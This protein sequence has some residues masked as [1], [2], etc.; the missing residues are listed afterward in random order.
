MIAEF[1]LFLEAFLKERNLELVDII[2]RYEGSDLVLRI[3]ADR[4]EGGIS[5]GE[6]AQLNRAIGEAL[7]ERNILEQGYILEVSS[8]GLDRPLKAEN[9]FKRCLN[10]KVRFFLSE[11]ING[12]LEWDGQ[13]QK[14]SEGKV[15]AQTGKGILEIPLDKINK[16]KQII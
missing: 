7:E 1:R 4:P 5:V 11:H 13:V 12:K 10:R 3:L 14:V 9:D 15:Y 6:C 8:P 2:H 16:A